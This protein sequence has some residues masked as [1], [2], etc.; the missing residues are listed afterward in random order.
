MAQWWDTA[1][2]P[3]PA[4]EGCKSGP[5]MDW[6]PGIQA[7]L[8]KV[9]I[10]TFMLQQ[11]MGNACPAALAAQEPYH[12]VR[13]TPATAGQEHMDILLVGGEAHQMGSPE[14]ALWQDANIILAVHQTTILT[15]CQTQHMPVCTPPLQGRITSVAS[16][17]PGEAVHMSGGESHA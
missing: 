10:R 6:Y 4:K 16:P 12:Y 5:E 9:W 14:T 2:R 3:N 15:P 13:T 1:V 17:R 8:L 7:L 11:Q